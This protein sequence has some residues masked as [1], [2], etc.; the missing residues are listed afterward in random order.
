[1]ISIGLTSFVQQSKRGGRN[2]EVS[3]SVIIA[4]VQH[5]SR[6]KREVISD[7]SVE[8]VDGEAMV[9]FIQAQT[10]RRRVLTHYLDGESSGVDCVG[11]YGRCWSNFCSRCIT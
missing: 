6:H 4:R 10:C 8:N 11:E 9:A 3:D 5:S 2:R 7:Y 1:V